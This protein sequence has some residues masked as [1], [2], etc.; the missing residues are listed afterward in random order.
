MAVTLKQLEA[1]I[2][3][4]RTGSFSAAAEL[5]HVSQPALTSMI[6]KLE[7]RLG[8]RLFERSSRGAALTPTGREL[9]PSVDRLIGEL[10]DTL[11]TV[12]SG[13]SPQGGIVS[14]ACIPSVAAVYLP[15]LIAEFERRYP[16]V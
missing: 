11:A 2:A 4:A 16:A 9:L 10:N 15:P 13:T 5:V 6:K 14:V 1:F 3:A 12:L 8:A 7:A